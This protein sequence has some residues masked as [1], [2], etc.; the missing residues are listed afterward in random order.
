MQSILNLKVKY[1]ESFRPFAPAVLR[2]DVGEWFDL[3]EDSPYMLLVAD[4]ARHR[5]CAVSADSADLFGIEKLKVRR[6]TIPAVT[7]VDYSA[8]IQTVHRE[9]NPRFYRLLKSFKAATH[10]PVL[11]N[12]SFNVRGEPIV[13][14]PE[15]ALRCFMGTEI[16]ALAIGNCFLRKEDQDPK[17]RVNYRN[18]FAPD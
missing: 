7:H 6:S 16:E 18:L 3:Q 14:S 5:R 9:T 4:V 12:T 15:D 1:R 10:C 17:L 11:V 13:N 8:R 2:E